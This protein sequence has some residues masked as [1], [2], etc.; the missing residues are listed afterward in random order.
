MS[1]V[2]EEH[3]RTDYV[4]VYVDDI[5]IFTK[6]DDPHEHLDKLVK[7]SDSLRQH[8]LL[9]KG[10]KCSLFRTEMEF[11]GFL[12]S[13][14]GTR[15]T[16]SKVESVVRMD[17][18]ETVSQLRSFLGMMNLFESHIAVFSEWASPLTDLLRGTTTG[19]QHLLWT[20]DA[21]FQY[22]DHNVEALPIQ[23][24]LQE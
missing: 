10:S 21:Q 22:D 7:V 14:D 3:I 19:R 5:C 23:I 11:L 12:V 18:P 17:P 24:V 8:D 9:E 2:L 16:P 13:T 20:Q 15:P 4:V 6:T 1:T